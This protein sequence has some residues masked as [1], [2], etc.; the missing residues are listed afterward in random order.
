MN[1][2]VFKKIMK[3]FFTEFKGKNATTK[4]FRTIAENEMH[5]DLGW[6]FDQWVDGTK[7]P[8][9]K[10]AYKTEHLESGKFVTKLKIKQENVP[11]DFKMLIPVK[12]TFNGSK[13]IRERIFMTG[14]SAEIDLPPYTY[15]PE[16]VILNDLESVLCE[17]EKVDWEDMN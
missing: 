15:I 14:G 2:D 16:D 3:K 5:I 7:I 6:F 8:S 13:P 9:Y 12:L 17:V 1:E 11:A 4:D 10:Y